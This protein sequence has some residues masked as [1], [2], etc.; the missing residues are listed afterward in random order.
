MRR[1]LFLL[2]LE[3]GCWFSKSCCI[4]PEQKKAMLT[5]EYSRLIYFT[6]RPS[7]SL[8]PEWSVL[9]FTEGGKWDYFIEE[10]ECT[11][12]YWYDKLPQYWWI[13]SAPVNFTS[14]KLAHT[15]LQGAFDHEKGNCF[16]LVTSVF[17]RP[18][19]ALWNKHNW[20]EIGILLPWCDFTLAARGRV[21]LLR[22]MI[23][24]AFV[25]TRIATC[26]RWLVWSGRLIWR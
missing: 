26:L 8:P 13:N 17:R 5:W 11:Q 25:E 21:D 7:I 20:E 1:P 6:N 4:F 23:D 10:D 18:D 24:H 2:S 16:N 22:G 15:S 19:W 3:S 12:L 14:T 9:R